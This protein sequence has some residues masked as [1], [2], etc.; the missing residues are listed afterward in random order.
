M[1][2]QARIHSVETVLIEDAAS[3]VALIQ[4]LKRDGFYKA[5]AVKPKDTK[6]MRLQ[7]QTA[8]I[9][10]G[11]VFLP[12]SAPWLETYL[13]ELMMFPATIHKDQ[14]DSTTQA[15][16]FLSEEEDGFLL[17]IRRDLLE[18]TYRETPVRA[19]HPQHDIGFHLP[20]GRDVKRERDG[21]YYFTENEWLGMP[22]Q[23]N[24]V[25]VPFEKPSRP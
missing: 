22:D 14:V 12:L 3:G 21:Y 24:L 9:E 25:R 4:D 17:M 8:L 18:K 5:Q 20:T 16:A 23:W 1:L 19:D 11:M 10:A 6:M 13:H 7:A 2:D 15:L